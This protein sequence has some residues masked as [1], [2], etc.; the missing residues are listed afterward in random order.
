MQ[1]MKSVK[2]LILKCI[3]VNIGLLYVLHP[4]QYQIKNG[5]HTISHALENYDH[6]NEH[7]HSNSSMPGLEEYT[8]THNEG[9]QHQFI[10]FI[11]LLFGEN[12]TY[13]DSK[14]IFVLNHKID[15]HIA[16]QQCYLIKRFN[17]YT[18]YFI[19]QKPDKTTKGYV[20]DIEQP[21]KHI[22]S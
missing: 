10:E 19:N 9:H 15:K 4:L 12:S 17:V 13:K 14:E 5:L 7:T 16:T 1:R 6:V 20:K 18:Y 8:H 2:L 3:A 11:N 21:P 22:L